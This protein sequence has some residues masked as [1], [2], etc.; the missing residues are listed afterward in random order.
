MEWDSHKPDPAKALLD[1]A[2]AE[3]DRQ[4]ASG[5][6]ERYGLRIL[7][8]GWTGQHGTLDIVAA[9][10]RVLVVCQIKRRTAKTTSPLEKMSRAKARRLRR[11]AAAWL[12]AHGVAYDEVRVDVVGLTKDP[13]GGFT[14]EHVRGVA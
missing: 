3:V 5:Y 7:D 6:L 8:R 11:L 12:A 9:E 2:Q 13:G 14:V 1:R 10:R 4:I